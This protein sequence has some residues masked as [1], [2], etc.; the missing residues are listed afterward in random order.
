MLDGIEATLGTP[1]PA[2]DGRSPRNAGIAAIGCALP[3]RVV[4]NDPIAA[5]LGIEPRWITSRTGVR[6]R[7]VADGPDA[8]TE[9]STQAA[10]EALRR[11]GREATDVD[12]VL[13]A[14]FTQDDLLP[15]AAP[16]V[17]ERL[18]AARAGALDLGA[19]CTG[20]LH[21]LDLAAAQI[22]SGRARSVLVIGADVLSRVIDYDDRRTAGLFGDG[23]GAALVTADAAGGLGPFVTRAD[24]SEAD[25]ITATHEERL[26]RMRGQDTFRA[27]VDR[28]SETTLEATVAAG[29]ELDEVDLFVYHQANGRILAA[30]GERLGLARERVVDCIA[31]YGNTSAASIPIALREA[32]LDG[33]LQPG[34]TVMLGAF[35]SGF[36]WGAGVI[37]WGPVEA[38]PEAARAQSEEVTR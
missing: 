1:F 24:G 27:A 36:V 30:L 35:A 7:R 26:L 29:I 33:R 4:T 32:E 16:L 18:G 10:A 5:R 31:A 25:C 15:N 14:S 37:E 28:L 12:L 17:A 19:A 20:L 9:L 6:E 2:R 11:G 21:G 38:E 13:V 3:E 23:A 34:H 8:L 22:E